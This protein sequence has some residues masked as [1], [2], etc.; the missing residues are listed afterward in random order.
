[1]DTSSGVMI[2][3]TVRI[4]HKSYILFMTLHPVG[5]IIYE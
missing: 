5:C 3:G 4:S 1:M 2:E